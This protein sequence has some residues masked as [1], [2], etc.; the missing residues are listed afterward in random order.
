M[1]FDGV[2]FKT[3]GAGTSPREFTATRDVSFTVQD[4]TA[5]ADG[6]HPRPERLRQEHHP[7]SSRASA[8]QFLQTGG[9]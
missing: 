8:P 9:S 7:G 3:Y 2:T 6:R 5:A 1:H 4:F